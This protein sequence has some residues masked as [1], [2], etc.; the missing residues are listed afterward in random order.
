MK[1][2]TEPR[3]GTSVDLGQRLY[4]RWAW[5][6]SRRVAGVPSPYLSATALF[7]S[8]PLRPNLFELRPEAAALTCV[9]ETQVLPLLFGG[10]VAPVPYSRIGRGQALDLYMSAKSTRIGSWTGIAVLGKACFSSLSVP[11]LLSAMAALKA[12]F[13]GLYHS[14]LIAQMISSRRLSLIEIAQIEPRVA[15]SEERQFELVDSDRFLFAAYA[16]DASR[17][18]RLTGRRRG[19]LQ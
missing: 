10:S 6:N 7:L 5:A 13:R 19:G 3:R 12:E 2:P 1:L 16:L 11:T 4:R 17:R 8:T 18:A 9:R 14:L 15:I